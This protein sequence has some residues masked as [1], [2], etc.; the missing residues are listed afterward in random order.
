M[1]K[2]ITAAV[3]IKAIFSTAAF[4]HS[5]SHLK[6][7]WS[8]RIP[9]KPEVIF[10]VIALHAKWERLGLTWH[11]WCEYDLGKWRLSTELIVQL[12]TMGNFILFVGKPRGNNVLDNMFAQFKKS[13]HILERQPV[14]HHQVPIETVR[15]RWGMFSVRCFSSYLI[16]IIITKFFNYVLVYLCNTKIYVDW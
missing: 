9:L 3:Y 14:I 8:S 10:F 15:S 7:A 1:V 5:R 13:D 2:Y 12:Y 6:S 4:Y 16:G 11:C